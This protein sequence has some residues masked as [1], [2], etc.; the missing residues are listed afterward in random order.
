M[1][2]RVALFFSSWGYTGYAPVASGTVGTLAAIPLF[3][4]FA[5][6]DNPVLAVVTCVVA[7]A[8]ACWVADITDRSIGAHD[9]GII[10][11]DE[12]VG[13]LVA[14]LLLPATWTVTVYTFFLFRA[15][16][17]I[18]PYPASY[19]DAKV[20]GG[21]G[22]V[23]DDVFAGIYANLAARLLLALTGSVLG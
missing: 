3:W 14:T 13:Y 6:I 20:D 10:V 8:A 18:K 5:K 15:F 23:L 4:I 19:I 9:S 2:Q 7:I 12:V 22:V 11:I 17:V 21:I 1:L 16:D